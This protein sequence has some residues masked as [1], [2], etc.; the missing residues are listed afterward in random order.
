MSAQHL[1]PRISRSVA[2]P[3]GRG[4]RRPPLPRGRRTSTLLAAALAGA[5]TGCATDAIEDPLVADQEA[6]S[7]MSRGSAELAFPGERGEVRRG[8]VETPSGPRELSYEL[9]HGYAVVEGDILLP[10]PGGKP[11]GTSRTRATYRWPGGVVPYTI[12]PALPDQTRVT[13]AIAH[14]EAETDLDFVARVA[15]ADY[16]TFRPSTGCS[17]SVGRV[18][19][20]QFINL[21]TG[22]TTGN[23]IH[24]IGHA[25]GMWHEQARADR[26]NH[27]VVNLANVEPGKEHNFNTFSAAGNDGRDVGAYGLDSIMHYGSYAFS[28]NG[29]PTITEIGGGIITAQRTAVTPTD[30]CTVQRFHGFGQRSDINGDG[31]ADLVV[32]VP[33]ED[34]AAVGNEGAIAVFFGGAAGLTDTDAF[35]HR[36]LAGVEDVAGGGDQFGYAVTVGDFDGDCLADV[37]VGVPFDDVD[38]VADAGSV[39]VFYGTPLGLGLSDDQVWHQD[40]PGIPGSAT[41]GDQFGT[42]LTSGDFNGDGF[43]DLAV[44]IPYKDI[45]ALLDTGSVQVLYGSATGLTAT[46]SQLWNQNT[47]TVQE[48]SELGDHFGWALAAGDFDGDGFDSLAVGVPDEAVGAVASAGVVHVL[49]GSIS[50]LS[51]LGNQMMVEDN[52]GIPGTSEANDLFGFALAAADFDS[53]GDSDLAIGVPLEEVG[54]VLGAGSVTVMYGTPTGILTTGATSWNQDSAGVGEACEASDVFGRSLEVGDFDAD[55]Y[56]DLAIGVPFEDVGAVNS[57]GG[58]QLLRG[59]A[60]GI[61]DVGDLFFHQ[62]SAGIAE[63][64]EAGDHFGYRLR[65]GDFDGDGVADLA[66]GVP[67]ESV[68][69]VVDAGALHVL[70][71]DAAGLSATGSQLWSQDST[72]IL[73]TSETGDQFSFGL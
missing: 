14:W 63:V 4:A 60:T 26:G 71:G 21:T 8:L 23:T 56:P 67:S 30:V 34:T 39:H 48:G 35:L 65:S 31:H 62:D 70:L 36:D 59:S 46:G 58:L 9:L 43:A 19:G 66:V 73:D 57:A 50:G 49:Q 7:P 54:G 47:G 22:C 20:Q 27:I 3:P 38:G 37:A 25:L 2:G 64:A 55:G 51:D 53:D 42:A 12:D 10:A 40:S 24:E 69:A 72:N 6:A 5:L 11:R 45:G 15:Q 18:G 61:T 41:A 1:P 33:N 17:S 13:D 16:V 29:L 68:G 52:P 32:G 44:G 28:I